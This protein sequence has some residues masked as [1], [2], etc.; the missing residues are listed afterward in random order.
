MNNVITSKEILAKLMAT[1]NISVEHANVSTASFDLK[2]RKLVIPSWKDISDD[3]YTLLISHEV[4]HALYTPFDELQNS[5]KVENPSDLKTIINIVEDVR[6]EKLIQNKF[7]G[8]IRSFRIGYNELENKNIFG[9]KDRD[10]ESYGFLDRINVHFKIGHFGYAKVPFTD[11]E[12]F[13]VNKIKN[14]LTFSDVVKV[15]KE[16]LKFIS[17][18]NKKK[19]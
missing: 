11:D 19:F 3:L 4:G 9:T 16:L 14:C 8:T 10:I 7:P 5:L 2:T 15:S 13:W 18:T 17:D 6:I 1:E 12:I